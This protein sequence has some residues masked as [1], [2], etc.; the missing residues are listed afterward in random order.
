MKRNM[1][2]I[3][4]KGT[5]VTPKPINK[6]AKS[7]DL[8][9]FPVEEKCTS[10]LKDFLLTDV[11]SIILLQGSGKEF[12]LQSIIEKEN[13]KDYTLIT[14]HQESCFTGSFLYTLIRS[15]QEKILIVPC[16]EPFFGCDLLTSDYPPIMKTINYIREQN[17]KLIILLDVDCNEMFTKCI[18]YNLKITWSD[19]DLAKFI[20]SLLCKSYTDD[21]IKNFQNIIIPANVSFETVLTCCEILLTQDLIKKD[22]S[23][24]KETIATIVNQK[25]KL[26]HHDEEKYIPQVYHK[27]FFQKD[28][29][30]CSKRGQKISFD[31]LVNYLINHPDERYRWIFDGPSGTGKTTAAIGLLEV[32]KKK[33]IY[34]RHGQ[35]LSSGIGETQKNIEN[36]FKKAVKED[37]V[38]VVNEADTLLLERDTDSINKR[39]ENAFTNAWIYCFDLYYKAS[40]IVTTNYVKDIDTAVDRRFEKFEFAPL[41]EKE[42]IATLFK[43][44]F[45]GHSFS[46]EQIARLSKKSVTPSDFVSVSERKYKSTPRT[47]QEIFNE[48]LA[49]QHEKEKSRPIGF[50]I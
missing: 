18:S 30:N 22:K 43:T 25:A 2:I 34:V 27:E 10:C 31:E 50:D 4:K 6:L 23:A 16:A 44:F 36:L 3:K 11:G 12:F 32:C 33:Y 35:L 39:I 38:I 26:E 7:F 47:S 17:K 49:I 14:M 46:N 21:E 45:P 9:L 20:H 15:V 19:T 5:Q 29:I 42:Q 37:L 13:I 24:A 8:N 40:V 28:L 1:K 41:T 48:L